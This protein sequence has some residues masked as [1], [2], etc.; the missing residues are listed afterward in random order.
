MN[1]IKGDLLEGDWDYACHVANNYCVMGS[2]VAYFLR[3]K[4]PQVFQADLDFDE[5]IMNE[6]LEQTDKMG[7]FSFADIG[8]N[9]GVFN[10]YA[11]WG[12]GSDGHPLHR[13]CSYD[14]LFN[15]LYKMAETLTVHE[16]LVDEVTVGVPKN[17][18]CVRA[19]GAWTIVEAIL[20]EVETIFPK[21]KF[22][23]YELEDAE[24]KAASSVTI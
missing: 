16:H 11:M 24:L 23:I 1:L 22:T 13:N 10:L 14:S 7:R 20:Q 4:W 3:K 12:V 5:E 2:G 15:A 19:G 9:R 6:G 8:D 17:M 21:I 18:G